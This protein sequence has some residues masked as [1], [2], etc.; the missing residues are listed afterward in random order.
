MPSPYSSGY[1]QF[2]SSALKRVEAIVPQC[3]DFLGD[4]VSPFL[5]RG[6]FVIFFFFLG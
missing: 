4:A 1:D 2:G 3:G 6:S 5:A